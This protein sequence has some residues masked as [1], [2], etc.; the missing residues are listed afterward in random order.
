[1]AELDYELRDDGVLY[2]LDGGTLVMVRGKSSGRATVSLQR[3]KSVLAPETGNLGGSAFRD[4]LA[5]AAR[6]RFAEVNGLAEDLGNIAAVFDRHL[7]EREEEA[8]E[9]HRRTADP[10][11][12]GT[13]YRISD[14]GGFVRIK[15]TR[16]GGIPEPLANFVARVEEEVLVDDGAEQRRIFKVSGRTGERRLPTVDVPTS[17]FNNMNWVSELWGLEAHIYAHQN[18]FVKEAIELYSRNAVK[19]FRYAHTGWRVLEDGTR[20]YLHSKGAIA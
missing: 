10:E 12:V 6:K 19:R 11:F 4:K 13:P 20:V 1:M 14:A 17:Q 9:H 15:S 2:A 5:A 3:G 18:A 7:K 16:E 8:E